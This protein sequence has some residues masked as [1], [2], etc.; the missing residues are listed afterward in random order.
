MI[1]FF[2]NTRPP[3][4]AFLFERKSLRTKS[5]H[6]DNFVNTGATAGFRLDNLRWRYAVTTW[7]ALLLLSTF[8]D[9]L[10]FFPR[11]PAWNGCYILHSVITSSHG[12]NG[13]LAFNDIFHRGAIYIINEACHHDG[14]KTSTRVSTCHQS[15]YVR[16][17]LHE[18]HTALE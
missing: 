16:K 6:D 14:Y 1:R 13:S 9:V 4:Q 17:G 18:I 3:P 10:S 11:G 5:C 7:R 15:F 12:I 8:S 2:Q